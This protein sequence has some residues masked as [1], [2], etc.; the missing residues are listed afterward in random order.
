[1]QYN[2]LYKTIWPYQIKLLEEHA[3]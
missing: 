2:L 1:M 3:Q